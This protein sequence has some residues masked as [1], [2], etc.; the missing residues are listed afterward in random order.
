MTEQEKRDKVIKGLERCIAVQRYP[1]ELDSGCLECP[2][3]PDNMGTC[4]HLDVLFSDALEL[5]KAQEEK[6]VNLT[7]KIAELATEQEPVEPTIGRCVEYDGHDSWWYECGKCHTPID[8]IDKYC[9]NCGRR[10]KWND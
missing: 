7:T 4:P 6:V 10:L 9:R 1:D 5:L 3:R 8:P 2:Y